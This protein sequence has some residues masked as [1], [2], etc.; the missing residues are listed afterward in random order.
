MATI[1]LTYNARNRLA[2]KTLDYVLSL[3]V[4]ENSTIDS[5]VRGRKTG[6]EEAMEDV[7]NGRVYEAKDADDLIRQCLDLN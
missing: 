5:K 3:G 4:F 6:L 1:T 2:Q 7:K